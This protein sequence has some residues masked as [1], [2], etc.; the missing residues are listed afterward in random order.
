MDKI[1]CDLSIAD[2]KV[3]IFSDR[4][5]PIQDNLKNFCAD[6]ESADVVYITLAVNNP[7]DYI[8][9]D[10]KRVYDGAGMT[11]FESDGRI[12]HRY[13]YG[14]EL[15][16]LDVES[17][18]IYLNATRPINIQR[19]L[20]LETEILDFDGIFMHASLIKVGDKGVIFSAPSGV[21]KSTQAALWEKHRG[22]RVL[23]GDRAA[24]RFVNGKWFAYGSPWAGS[25]G[26]YVNDS[27][28]L[29]AI[30]FL[31]QSKENEIKKLGGAAAFGAMMKG[32]I[33]PYWSKAK[34]SR[35]CAVTEQLLSQIPV[36]ELKCRPDESAVETLERFI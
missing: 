12:Y 6:F 27:V 3:R 7:D 18:T 15:S 11:V 35:V 5:L 30:V 23:N 28:D 14:G 29:S 32:G 34:M 21:G 2:I 17:R 1:R 25:S 4:A 24:V 20:S 33:F 22:A 8:P 10:A 9:A 26:I 31:G 16:V 13:F 36:Y 19:S